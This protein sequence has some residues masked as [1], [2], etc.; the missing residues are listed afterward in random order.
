VSEQTKQT[1][2]TAGARWVRERG[3]GAVGK[4]H[5]PAAWPPA[6]GELVGTICGR[7]VVIDCSATVP[8][9]GSLH[10]ACSDCAP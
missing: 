3:A 5:R 2:A 7:D 9:G 6:A 10:P 1:A 4:W 8:G